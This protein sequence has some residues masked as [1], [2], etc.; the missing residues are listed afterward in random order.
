MMHRQKAVV[1]YCRDHA[2]GWAATGVV[3]PRFVTSAFKPWVCVAYS[4]DEPATIRSAT[5]RNL[6]RVT[7]APLCVT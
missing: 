6:L 7:V 3:K 1:P 4:H 5:V 2:D